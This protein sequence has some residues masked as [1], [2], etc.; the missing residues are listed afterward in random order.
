V[1]TA[2]IQFTQGS[3]V[4]TA[5]QA[6]VGSTGTAVAVANN[7]TTGIQSWSIECLDSP[8]G[9]TVPKTTLAFSNSGNTPAA[10]F[11]P[12][13]P[14]SYRIRLNVWDAV[15]RPGTP[16]DVDIRVFAVRE[17]NGFICPPYQVYPPQLPP[18]ASGLAGNK[19]DEMNF[20]GQTNGWAGTGTDGLLD[21]L[22]KSANSG[23]RSVTAGLGIS[24]TGTSSDPVITNTGIRSLAAGSGIS[25]SGTAYD[26]TISNTGILSITAGSG[27]TITG[28]TQTP[29]ISASG[30]A[31]STLAAAYNAGTSDADQT[32]LLTDTHSPTPG[33][34]LI[35]DSTQVSYT[36][37]YALLIKQPDV[38]TGSF[39]YT[40]SMAFN[41]VGGL[42]ASVELASAFVGSWEWLVNGIGSEGLDLSFIL[43]ATDEFGTNWNPFV[44]DIDGSTALFDKTGD[45]LVISNGLIEARTDAGNISLSF[46]GGAPVS[47]GVGVIGISNCSTPPSGT[48]SAGGVLY[49]DTGVL[50]FLSGNGTITTIAPSYSFN[51]HIIFFGA[52]VIPSGVPMWVLDS[53]SDNTALAGGLTSASGAEFYVGQPLTKYRANYIATGRSVPSGNLSIN[54]TK[55]GSVVATLFTAS[56]SGS[57]GPSGTASGSASF[58]VGDAW[59]INLTYPGS[60]NASISFNLEISVYYA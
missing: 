6:L 18:P 54:L 57:G 27:I 38:T 9:S 35:I 29:T 7:S 58:S 59:G 45:K 52:F 23:V 37:L 55:N 21:N 34:G 43:K 11:T 39:T 16:T 56:G 10:S 22:I 28:S 3:T 14:G 32:L 44:S 2:L 26:K 5:G 31:G 42:L 41:R 48:P 20:S 25:I 36:G 50:K 51:R 30:L 1:A 8:T 33:N 17:A 4:G 15:S 12:D 46:N 19:P 60:G 53:N 24:N 40:P 13:I 49:V 47:G